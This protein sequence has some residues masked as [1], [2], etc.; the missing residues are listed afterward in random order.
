[1]ICLINQFI[2]I[3]AT[4]ILVVILILFFESEFEEAEEN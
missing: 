4:L 1:M 2:F 3:I